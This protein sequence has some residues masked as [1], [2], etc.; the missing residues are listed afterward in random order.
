MHYSILDPITIPISG[1]NLIEASAGT[2]KT[3]NIAALFTRLIAVEHFD[4]SQILV[5]TFSKNATAELKNRLRHNLDNALRC[6]MRRT[7]TRT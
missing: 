2:G 3:Y 1:I 7:Q 6:L 4:V 5:V